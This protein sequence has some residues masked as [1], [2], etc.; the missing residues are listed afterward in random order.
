[1]SARLPARSL[2]AALL[3]GTVVLPLPRAAE[4]QSYATPALDNRPVGTVSVTIANPS[5]DAALNDRVTDAV[6]RSLALFPGTRFSQDR[7]DAA[8]GQARRNPAVAAIAYDI[9]PGTT[10]TVDVAVTVTLVDDANPQ[11][12]EGWFLTGDRS[13][14]PLA[15][16][17]D[18]TRLQFKLEALTLYYANN[19]AWYGRPDLM[20]AGNPLVAGRPAGAGYDDWVETYLHYGI[21]G[22][23]PLSQ[24]FYVYG[25]LSAIT[26]GSY[27]Q[28]LF[29]DE[30][31][32]YTGVE[33]AYLG[34]ITGRTDAAGNRL[35]FNLSAGRQRFTLANAFLI[36]NT[37]ANGDERAALQANARWSADLVVLG[38]LVWN[39]TKIEAFWVDPDELPLL[40]SDT[41]IAGV[42]VESILSP[43]L[44]LGASW[45]TV[46]RSNQS[47]FSPVGT[48][49]GTREGLDLWDAR[50]TY[51]QPGGQ[52]GFFGGAE[53]ARQ[54]N[55][56]F[57]MDARAAYG[58]IGYSWA[59]A[60]WSPAL[61]YRLSYFSGDDP[62]T[63]TYERWDPLLSGGTGEQWVQGAN[64]FKVVQDSNVIAHRLQG[65]LRIAPRVE[66]VPQL[67]A[68]YAD[69]TN[70]IGGNPA[71]TF[72]TDDEYGYEANL[73]VKWFASRNI[74]VHGHIAYTVPGQAVTDALGG[75]EEDWLSAMLFVR[76]AF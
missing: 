20:L 35:A 54:T 51:T 50:I 19:N 68:F 17:Q 44:L 1:M 26:S 6:R 37:A 69:Q 47:Y 61:S 38:Q 63:A 70:N 24:N 32:T 45:L 67:W 73:T 43:G 59:N 64:H 42:N 14:F 56:N 34:F 30:T 75:T 71:L 18:G 23:T 5:A 46:P 53:F 55:R 8:I 12:G 40:D 39:D 11:Q 3:L 7:A 25:G 2:V 48:I 74:Y 13:D 65:R 16:D 9:A 15:Y 10:G 52:P 28:E 22:I 66:L 72:M 57:D 76:Y 41:A 29:T 21:Y 31:R 36:A 60:T 62:D 49:A 33:D 4:A 27:G 58:E